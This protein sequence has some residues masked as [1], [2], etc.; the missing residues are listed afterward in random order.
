MKHVI[1]A[2]AA[3]LCLA[4]VGMSAAQITAGSQDLN[5]ALN[6]RASQIISMEVE[7]AADG[8]VTAYVPLTDATY[9]L[10]L[11]PYSLRAADYRVVAQLADG[12]LQEVEPGPVTT[13][14]GIVAEVPGVRVAASLGEDGFEGMVDLPD[15][16]WIAP[17]GRFVHG[18]AADQYVVYRQSDVISGGGIC[19]GPNFSVVPGRDSDKGSATGGGNGQRA[20][21]VAELAVDVDVEY[22]NFYGTISGV[23]TRVNNVMNTADVQYG[24]DVDIDHMITMILV[25]TAEPDPYTSTDPGTLLG[26]FRTEWLNNQTGVHRD[27]ALLFTGK[28]VDGS[29]IGIAWTIGGICT[30]GAYCLAQANCCGSLNCAGD[31]CAHELGHLWGAS[32]CTCS[33]S[34]M[35]PSITC[36]LNFNSTSQGQIIAHRNSRT[37]LNN[38]TSDPITQQPTSQTTCSGDQV[39]LNIT[40]NLALPAYQWRKNSVNLVDGPNI[41]GSHGALLLILSAT[42]ADAGNYDC[43]VTD[44]ITSCQSTS[45]LA[46]LTVAAS[47]EISIQPAPKTVSAGEPGFFSVTTT[48][49]SVLFSFQWRRDG[50]NLTDNANIF[51]STTNFLLIAVAAAN[52]E[53]N[54]D[55]VITRLEGGCSVTS[56]SAALTVN[57][58]GG[59]P[60][61]GSGK[62]ARSDIF[63]AGVGDCLV[64]LSDL[65]V[66]LANYNPGVG[67]K[68]REQGDVFG[69]DG[70]VD[71]SDLGQ[72]L[73]DFAAD[74]R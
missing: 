1:R 40:T 9:T 13:L 45:D 73:A 12:S 35:N 34:T 19:G 74:C 33:N 52:D 53:G 29:V 71:L 55:C 41:V 63:P 56:D 21:Y 32:H 2:T 60:N 44:S 48:E 68:T 18:A 30:S 57:S 20:G 58:T 27:V 59:C 54:Y 10:M 11:A 69:N 50:V 6:V 72:M 39:F 24:R 8:S 36:T 65:G 7:R 22:F 38:C 15:R 62:C 14:R 51:G 28:N 47:P 17:L 64:D 42:T 37:C 26:Q 67:G 3:A 49:P 61:D 16:L 70:F 4:F 25:R 43:V 23:E 5:S 31:L 66:L 46:T